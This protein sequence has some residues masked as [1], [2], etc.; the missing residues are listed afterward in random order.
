MKT[1]SIKIISGTIL[2]GLLLAGCGKD[3]VTSA[4][5]AIE[6]GQLQTAE[7]ILT[8]ELQENPANV[9]A[10]MNLAIVHL[11][12]GQADTAL[13]EFMQV[14]EQ[15]PNDPAPLEYAASIHMDNNRWPEAAALLAEGLRREPNSPRIQTAL[16]LVD[17]NTSGP[18]PAKD[19][20]LKIIAD[21]PTYAPALFNLGV[22]NR[23]WF[24]NQSESKKYFQRYLAIEK[25]DSHAVIAKVAL[26]EKSRPATTPTPT[27]AA[28]SSP[29]ANRLEPLIPAK[30]NPQ[31]AKESFTKGM[32][33]H[34]AR[35]VD[36]A[37][38]AYAIAL[39]NDPAMVRAHYNL[40][41]LL[42]DKKELAQARYEFEQALA[43][44]PG[45][46]DA[47]YMLALVL[48]DQKLEADATKHLL[49]LLEKNP[50][51]AQGHLALGLLY[52]KD[53]AKREL[54]RKELAIY[55]KLD[56]NGPPSREIRN[57]LKYLQ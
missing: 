33:Y 51:H 13:S 57:W 48:I 25:H 52:K 10:L 28:G 5:R 45:M 18:Q 41:L 42:Q 47:R 56:P 4:I 26:T 23:D 34:Q 55:L 6:Q 38:E 43:Y 37:M 15:A 2:S 31:L 7:Q 30:R 16:A 50:Q 1:N 36:K 49:T 27:S 14:A 39:Q 40:G 22:L 35:D 32:K 53:P 54:A 46:A 29:P 21:F 3:P 24:K 8:Q 19:R 11:K 44:S 20:L 17:L 12:N 9:N